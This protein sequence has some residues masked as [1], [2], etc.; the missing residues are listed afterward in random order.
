MDLKTAKELLFTSEAKIVNLTGEYGLEKL[1]LV[2]TVAQELGKTIHLDNL[3]WETDLSE[4]ILILFQN[5]NAIVALDE[6]ENL[7]NKILD[8][9]KDAKAMV[10]LISNKELPFQNDTKHLTMELEPNDDFSDWE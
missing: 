4:E 7:L 5:P 8:A 9:T 2:Q 3:L 1:S 10:I 6:P